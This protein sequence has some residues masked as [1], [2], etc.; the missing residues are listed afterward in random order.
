MTFSDDLLKIYKD[1]NAINK[2]LLHELS[3]WTATNILR[4][5]F[6][7]F[8]RG[9]YPNI[10]DALA[11]NCLPAHMIL[12]KYL[13][14]NY[15]WVKYAYIEIGLTEN[16]ENSITQEAKENLEKSNLSCTCRGKLTY[17]YLKYKFHVWLRV[18]HINGK[19]FILDLTS[20]PGNYVS[21]I[22][23]VPVI[24][25]KSSKSSFFLSFVEDTFHGIEDSK[26]FVREAIRKYGL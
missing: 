18:H 1:K 26:E 19:S 7:C 5:R 3:N 10:E 6:Y 4:Q 17:D 14:E 22:I 8:Y 15:P 13:A 20:F 23:Y 11:G 16:L 9:S 12:R 21:K 25:S 24:K 2:H